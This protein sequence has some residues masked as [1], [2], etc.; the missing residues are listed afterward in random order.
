MSNIIEKEFLFNGKAHTNRFN[1]SLQAYMTS[2]RKDHEVKETNSKNSWIYIA[3]QHFM[4]VNSG[5]GAVEP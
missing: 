2:N 3:I 4:I 5:G 1:K